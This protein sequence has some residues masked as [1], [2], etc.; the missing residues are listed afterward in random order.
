[1][2]VFISV[3]GNTAGDGFLVAPRGATYDAEIAL[4]TDVGTASVTLQASPNTA[5]LVFSQTAVNLSTAPTIVNVHSTLQ[6]ASRGD[7]TIQLLDG[8]TLLSSFTIT[9]I[10][11]P[12]VNF[13]G[14][15]EARFG[16]DG[17]FYNRNPIYSATVDA[18]VPPG[19]TWGLEGEPDFVPVIGN[20]PENLETPVGRIVRY[21]SPVAVRSY[22]AP[23]TSTVTSITGETSSG[24]ETFTTGDPLI[25]QPV[26][27]GPNTYLAGNNP[28]PPVSPANPAPEESWDAAL[29]PMALFEIHLGSLFS[30]VSQVGPFT[31]K[32]TA[33]NEQTRSPDS[34]P[35]ANGLVGAAAELAELGLPN[36]IFWWL[37]TT[38][39]RQVTARNGVIWFVALAIY[40]RR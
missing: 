4:W 11:R 23:V 32:A 36:L 1:M 15:F 17:G 9:S 38:R 22:A 27:L 12:V 6:S 29:E 31:H 35:R 2:A 5:G 30:G 37:I 16:T 21:N 33:T 24:T 10:K 19:W 39:C 14:R 26:N 18:V 28:I 8:A 7:T 3:G 40:F 25:G 20:V 34:R 13:N